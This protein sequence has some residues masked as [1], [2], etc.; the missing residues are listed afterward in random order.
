MRGMRPAAPIEG[1]PRACRAA[2]SLPPSLPPPADALATTGARMPPACRVRGR[3]AC[4]LPPLP[5]PSRVPRLEPGG[6]R[7]PLGRR[8]RGGRRPHPCTD[9]D[10]ALFRAGRAPARA[11]AACSKPRLGAAG[12]RAAHQ[13]RRGPGAASDRPAPAAP[14]AQAPHKSACRQDAARLRAGVAALADPVPAVV[15]TPVLGPAGLRAVERQPAASAAKRKLCRAYAALAGRRRRGRSAALPAPPPLVG[16]ICARMA[17]FAA[18]VR[19][20]PDG[21]AGRGKLAPAVRA[22]HA[23]RTVP[24]G[25][26]AAAG[27]RGAQARGMHGALLGVVKVAPHVLAHPRARALGAAGGR[28]VRPRPA[29]SRAGRERPAADAAHCRPVPR[30]AAGGRRIGWRRRGRGGS[31]RSGGQGGFA[32]A[33][34]SPLSARVRAVPD[35]SIGRLE[36]LAA[37]VAPHAVHP[38]GLPVGPLLAPR[39]VADG[40]ADAGPEPAAAQPAFGRL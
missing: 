29:L 31:G 39:A 37:R 21:E 3:R 15:G 28:A 9:A 1:R 20:V 10:G 17:L 5:S 11:L 27:R 30:P 6:A 8:G 35:G 2:H 32:A 4:S 40:A 18:C 23:P 33:S 7:A 16:R 36:R 22:L 12:V 24:S 38:G 34:A 26:G 13:G 14:A 25:N 19:A